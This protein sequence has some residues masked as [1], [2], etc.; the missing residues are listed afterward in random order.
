MIL[1][2]ISEVLNKNEYKVF[3]HSGTFIFR[4]QLMIGKVG[5]FKCFTMLHCYNVLK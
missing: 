1:L 2:L 5:K 3:P 4:K